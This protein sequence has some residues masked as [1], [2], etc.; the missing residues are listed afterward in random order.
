MDSYGI[1]E[2][3]SQS[4]AMTRGLMEYNDN[5]RA[6]KSALI[7]QG[8]GLK[9]AAQTQDEQDEAAIQGSNQQNLVK[10]GITGYLAEGKLEGLATLPGI[11]GKVSTYGKVGLDGKVVKTAIPEGET[12]MESQARVLRN[13]NPLASTLLDYKRGK[14]NI[15]IGGGVR[16]LAQGTGFMDAVP[17]NIRANPLS[18]VTG[19]GARAPPTLGARVTQVPSA[20]GD[21]ADVPADAAPRGAGR[22]AGRSL[23]AETGAAVNVAEEGEEVATI[24]AKAIGKSIVGVGMKVAGNLQGGADIIDLAKNGFHNEN[25]WENW[26]EGLT[27][28][29]TA[30]ETLGLAMPVFEGIGAVAGVVGSVLT[31]VGENAE[32][33]DDK[34]KNETSSATAIADN[35]ANVDK[36][37]TIVGT[38]FQAAGQ[39]AN[40]SQHIQNLGG[41]GTF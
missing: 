13:R 39:I 9:K 15:K 22:V 35:Q 18:S 28:F 23:T 11:R 4:N 37:R 14:V 25:R 12:F 16:D 41:V 6:R 26:G 7:S 17:T 32:K 38:S 34:L 19:V 24:G 40:Q 5:V 21:A 8:T 33:K 36:Q 10:S 1:N 2:A 3:I 31:A 20:F 27:A 30:A 29:G